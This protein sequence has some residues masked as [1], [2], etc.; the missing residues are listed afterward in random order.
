MEFTVLYLIAFPDVQAKVHR[1]VE[2]VIGS[3]LPRLEHRDRMTYTRAFMEEALRYMPA[4][5]MPP[6][7]RTSEDVKLSN[8]MTIPKDTQVLIN[9]FFSVGQVLINICKAR[10]ALYPHIFAFVDNN[11][12]AGLQLFPDCTHGQGEL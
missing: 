12:D 4:G 2:E 9:I 10:G 6:P 8:G 7:R 3:D 11:Y 1:E 5:V